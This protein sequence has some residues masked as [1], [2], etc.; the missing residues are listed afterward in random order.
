MV[1]ASSDPIACMHN[2]NTDKYSIKT[3][4][5]TLELLDVKAALTKIE[6]RKAKARR[7]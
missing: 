3:F 5:D 4:L 1:L 2:I 7:E 6:E